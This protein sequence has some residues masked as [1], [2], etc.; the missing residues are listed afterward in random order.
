[1]AETAAG[2][3]RLDGNRLRLL[4]HC[5]GCRRGRRLALSI[6]GSEKSRVGLRGMQVNRRH[7][8]VVLM[9]GLNCSLATLNHLDG[10]LVIMILDLIWLCGAVCVLRDLDSN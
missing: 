4:L 9:E 1:V 10:T 7:F 5:P 3:L 6:P 2:Q 8:A